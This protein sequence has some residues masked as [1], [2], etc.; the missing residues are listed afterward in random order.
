LIFGNKS[1]THA[2]AIKSNNLFHKLTY[3][4]TLRGL[5]ESADDFRKEQYIT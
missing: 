4:H 2:V 3:A 1:G 5:L